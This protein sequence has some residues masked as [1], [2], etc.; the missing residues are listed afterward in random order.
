M[1]HPDVGALWCSPNIDMPDEVARLPVWARFI[2]E[3][4]RFLAMSEGRAITIALTVP[5]RGFA[6]SLA[7]AA[8]ALTRDAREPM[9]PDDL[10]LHVGILRNTPTGTPIKFHS[11]DRIH[12]GRWIDVTWVDDQEMLRFETGRGVTRKLPLQSALM[13]RPTGEATAAGQLRAKRVQLP[14][15]L[16]STGNRSAALTYV[17]TARPDCVVVGTLTWLTEDLTAPV[18]RLSK[19]T[20]QPAS[21]LQTL[22]RARKVKGAGTYYRTV[23]APSG[24]QPSSE[25]RQMKP[26]VVIFDGGRGYI[27]WRHIWPAARQLVILDRSESSSEEAAN[28]VSEAFVNRVC[29]MALPDEVSVPDGVEAVCFERQL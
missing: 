15:L 3:C 9:A 24:S 7:A 2:A 5:T 1:S 8:V 20:S 16:Q 23:I 18:F 14:I 25:V 10:E 17:T 12:D 26:A 22:A 27:R 28:A 21:E 11:R 4:G 29:S 6:A 13:I 19:D